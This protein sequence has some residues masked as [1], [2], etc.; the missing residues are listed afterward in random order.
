MTE[1][2]NNKTTKICI[3]II[4]ALVIYILSPLDFIPDLVV[5]LGQSDDLAALLI[6]VVTATIGGGNY[7]G[8]RKKNEEVENSAV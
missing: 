7:L 2:N 1:K 5:G 3:I 4:I 8:N 6:A